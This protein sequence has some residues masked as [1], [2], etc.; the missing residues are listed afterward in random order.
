MWE[1]SQMTRQ[2]LRNIR[3]LIGNKDEFQDLSKLRITFDVKLVQ[4]IT[5]DRCTI[6]IYN[7]S[8]DFIKTALEKY[9]DVQLDVG[10]GS[11]LHSL[12]TGEITY[13]RSY[14]AENLTDRILT[15]FSSQNQKAAQFGFVKQTF[16]PGTTAQEAFTAMQQSWE[17]FG[18]TSD[19]TGS[20]LITP[21]TAY[22]RG[23]VLFGRTSDY[24]RRLGKDVNA[25]IKI[26]DGKVIVQSRDKPDTSKIFELNYNT[27]LLRQPEIVQLGIQCTCLLNPALTAGTVV[28]IDT[29]DIIAPM[30]NRDTHILTGLWGQISSSG[31]YYIL[32]ITHSGDTWGRDWNTTFLAAVTQNFS[33]VY[34]QIYGG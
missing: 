2:Y 28:H 18:I 4:S 20:E 14:W 19:P 16:E 17:Q 10:Y 12:Y 24:A 31:L 5:P 32:D 6:S 1:L 23:N 27:G 8:E 22:P 15:L 3:L 7:V 33:Q 26:R 13:W 29:K 30:P 21:G 34:E 25:T 9:T 11:E